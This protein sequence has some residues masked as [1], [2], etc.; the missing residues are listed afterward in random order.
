MELQVAELADEGIKLRN[1]VL[2]AAACE[3]F[4][5]LID[6][7]GDE[8]AKA[9]VLHRRAKL[10]PLL[11]R[12]RPTNEQVLA[13]FLHRLSEKMQERLG[14]AADAVAEAVGAQE[15]ELVGVDMALAGSPLR[16]AV[17]RRADGNA[18]AG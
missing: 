8:M 15:L 10:D 16:R 1:R 6:R 18:Q 7:A 17:L 9:Y 4:D 12:M 5:T 14:A 2:E 11:A 3:A 13:G